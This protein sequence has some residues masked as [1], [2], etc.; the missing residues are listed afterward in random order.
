MGMYDDVN[1]SDALPYSEEMKELGLDKNDKGFQTKDL[2]CCLS[3]YYIQGNR[4]FQEFYKINEWVEGDP[5]AKS[6]MDIIGYLKREEPY[7]KECIINS[8]FCFHNYVHDAQ[9]KW[10]CWVE[11]KAVVQDG[12]IARYELVKFEKTDNTERKT[13]EKEWKEEIEAQNR[14]WYNKYIFHTSFWYKV[15]RYWSSTCYKLSNIFH[16]LANKCP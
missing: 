16:N 4:L 1:I 8:D 5:K 12:V 10:D 9:D 7:L 14:L 15:R 13:R 3:K 2:D 11:F 6:I